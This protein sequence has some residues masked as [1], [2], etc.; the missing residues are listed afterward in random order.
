MGGLFCGPLRCSGALARKPRKPGTDLPG[1][2]DAEEEQIKYLWTPA[3]D[4]TCLFPGSFLSQFILTT[5]PRAA[6]SQSTA[7]QSC[8]HSSCNHFSSSEVWCG[9]D[10]SPASPPLGHTGKIRNLFQQKVDVCP[11]VRCSWGLNCVAHS[12]SQ[13]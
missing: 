6:Q 2:E 7:L 13:D 9:G 10:N 12:F 4:R 3:E 8:R 5:A 1:L 11:L